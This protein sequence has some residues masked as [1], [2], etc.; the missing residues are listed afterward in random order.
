MWN[1]TRLTARNVYHHL[2]G[3]EGTPDSAMLLK[4]C[5]LIWKRRIPLKIKIFGWL[6]LL[7]RLTTRSFRQ[8]FCPGSS[9]ECPLCAGVSEDFLISFSSANMLRRH[10][11]QHLQATYISPQLNPFGTLLPGG[12]LGAQQNGT[13]SSPI[14]GRFG[15]IGTRWSSE[16]DPRQSTLSST[17]LGE[18]PTTG[19]EAALA[20]RILYLCN[21]LRVLFHYLNEIGGVPLR[22]PLLHFSK[23][24]IIIQMFCSFTGI[25]LEKK[26]GQQNWNLFNLPR[27]ST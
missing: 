7:Q 8:R 10:G 20:S 1:G 25:H 13:Q 22:A 26:P 6:L 16:V 19:I 9:T 21:Q 24:I 2:Q 15:Y 23:K 11:G 3:L 18:L 17:T 14:C 5:W 4:C 27:V 12:R